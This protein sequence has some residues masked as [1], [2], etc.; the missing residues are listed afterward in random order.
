MFG[1]RLVAAAAFTTLAVVSFATPASAADLRPR[2]QAVVDSGATGAIVLVDSGTT[3]KL[4][5][6]VAS[7][8]TGEP[9]RPDARVRIASVT[10]TFVAAVTLQL[11][12][13]AA[14]GDFTLEHTVESQLPGLLPNGRSITVRQ[15][16][17]HTSGLAEYA[18]HPWFL[19]AT[20]LDPQVRATPQQLL[21]LANELRPCVDAGA[22][23]FGQGQAGP[24]QGYF[25]ANTN[26]IVLGMILQARTGKR[27]ED[28]V[29]QRIITPLNLSNT[30]FPTGTTG[31]PGYDTRIPGY[32]ARGYV[33][34]D[35]ARLI[36]G[37]PTLPNGYADITEYSPTLSWAAGAMISTA[38]DLQKFFTEL[39]SGRVVRDPLLLAQMKTGTRWNGD[40][41][42]GLQREEVPCVPGGSET[43]FFGHDGWTPGYHTY[44]RHAPAGRR[45]A[46]LAVPTTAFIENVRYTPIVAPGARLLDE[47]ACA[48]VGL[49]G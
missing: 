38:D 10:K 41:G 12:D 29:R 32:H 34:P 5:A 39:L 47:A 37:L 36:P 18:Y 22:P 20:W 43:E 19:F 2:L 25:Y 3:T 21:A 48:S 24:D 6:G 27:V 14:N 7:L 4:A 23:C 35:I 16:L 8:A 28:L 17:S 33:H 9:L 46:V 45:G 11:V 26:Y 13:E 40:Y 42:L 30:L 49:A 31:I 1:R 44:I 15:L